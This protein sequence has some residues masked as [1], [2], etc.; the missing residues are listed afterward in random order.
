MALGPRI[1]I[2][3]SHSL[4]MTPQLQQAIKLLQLSN[5]ELSEFI[6]SEVERNPLLERDIG[7]SE[8]ATEHTLETQERDS[9]DY[10]AQNAPETL[11]GDNALDTDYSNQYDQDFAGAGAETFENHTLESTRS[12]HKVNHYDD[13]NY[14]EHII[15]NLSKQKS[16]REH[17]EEQILID[18]SNPMDRAIA[19]VMLDHLNAQGWFSGDIEILSMQLGV[20]EDRIR[21][22]LQQLQKM[23]PAGIFA[24][25]LSECLRTQLK[26]KNKFDSKMDTLLDHLHLIAEGKIARLIRKCKTTEE[27]VHKMVK[28]LQELQP[29]PSEGFDVSER[30]SIIPDTILRRDYSKDGQWTIELNNST[31]PRLKINQNLRTQMQTRKNSRPEQQYFS[32]QLQNARWL[33]KSLEQRSITI[34]KVAKE[35]VMQQSAFFDYGISH[36]KP[37]ILRDIADK[38]E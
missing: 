3:Q 15:A 32:E 12:T 31:L 22:V 18:L 20:K 13:D 7:L 4:V 14:N 26:L 25:N 37:L 34:L 36:L 38:V 16:L 24:P 29:R 6:D 8:E 1:D 21:F 35:I 5:L 10:L 33:E 23:D 28:E 30:T 17:L 9:V 19:N 11:I 27:E 2:N